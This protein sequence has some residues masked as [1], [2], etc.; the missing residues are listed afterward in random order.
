MAAKRRKRRKKRRW[1]AFRVAAQDRLSWIR[2]I[3]IQQQVSGWSILDSDGHVRIVRVGR[4]DA[5]SRL[6]RAD[7]V[8]LG[9]RG[10]LHPMG[11]PRKVPEET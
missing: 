10:G 7:A 11:R 6:G 2:A 5:A 8:K 3:R 4:G 9:L 1:W